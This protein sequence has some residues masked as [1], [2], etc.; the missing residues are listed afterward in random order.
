MLTR[1]RR[2]LVI[3]RA[4]HRDTRPYGYGYYTQ[5][6]R[7]RDTRR[8]L[9][10][11]RQRWAA[12]RTTNTGAAKAITSV[13]HTGGSWFRM[14][15]AHGRSIGPRYA[16]NFSAIPGSPIS[17]SYAI[18]YCIHIEQ[19]CIDVS[20]VDIWLPMGARCRIVKRQP[21]DAVS[22]CSRLVKRMHKELTR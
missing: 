19:L 11:M 2:R 18:G 6:E 7:D 15:D 9:E 1:N 3:P 13:K 20:G 12:V 21:E 10:L 22:Y 5:A 8:T 17:R 4:N 14:V 16:I